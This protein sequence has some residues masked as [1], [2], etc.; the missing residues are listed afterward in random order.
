MLYV[1]TIED[2]VLLFVF[3]LKTKQ[4]TVDAFHSS[5]PSA[6]PAHS[7]EIVEDSSLGDQ[8]TTKN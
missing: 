8:T 1:S 2:D 4:N 3:D 6:P 5:R 7:I